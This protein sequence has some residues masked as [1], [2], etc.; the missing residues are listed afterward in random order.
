MTPLPC[1]WC[2][3]PAFGHGVRYAAMVGEHEWTPGEP[4]TEPGRSTTPTV[5]PHPDG[6][7]TM[8]WI[9]DTDP[10]PVPGGGDRLTYGTRGLR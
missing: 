3:L 7:V 1:N 5:V 2:D 9:E 6:G 8:Q 4:P 10:D